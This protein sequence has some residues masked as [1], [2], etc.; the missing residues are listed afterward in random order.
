MVLARWVSFEQ[1]GKC[2]LISEVC[3]YAAAVD[4]KEAR[5]R[6]EFCWRWRALDRFAARARLLRGVVSWLLCRRPDLGASFVGRWRALDSFAAGARLLRGVVTLAVV[7]GPTRGEFCWRWR[8]L[9]RFA[10][11]ARL[12]RGCC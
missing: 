6:G 11:R 10:A 8:A 7:G 4:L 5:P 3:E 1:R 2:S 9:D 12:L